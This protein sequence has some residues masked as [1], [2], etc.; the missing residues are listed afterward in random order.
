VNAATPAAEMKGVAVM[1]EVA[2][3]YWRYRSIDYSLWD[4][5]EEAAG[6]AAAMQADGEGDAAGVQFPDG[7]LVPAA[8]WNAFQAARK[9]RDAC[10]AVYVPPSPSARREIM[11]P[12]G[13]GLIEIDAREPSWLGEVKS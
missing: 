1:S 8:E 4:S 12:F 9:A 13:G 7:R 5:E 6:I 2:L 11:A 10:E 3:W